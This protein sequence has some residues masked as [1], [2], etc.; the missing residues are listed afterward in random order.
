MDT[1]VGRYLMAAKQRLHRA[2][3]RGPSLDRAGARRGCG[4]IRSLDRRDEPSVS[5]Y[6]GRVVPLL[7]LSVAAKVRY[8]SQAPVASREKPSARSPKTFTDLS[9]A[10]GLG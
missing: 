1:Q 7:E 3:T 10:S 9:C 5:G 4:E 6:S 8:M 2:L